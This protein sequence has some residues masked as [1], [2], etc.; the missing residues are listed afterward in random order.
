MSSPLA[1][2]SFSNNIHSTRI[3]HQAQA[4]KTNKEAYT[5]NNTPIKRKL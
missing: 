2:Q 1:L 3:N 4:Y 5:K